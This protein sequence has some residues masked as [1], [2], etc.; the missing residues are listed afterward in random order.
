MALIVDWMLW[1]L[2]LGKERF[3]KRAATDQGIAGQIPE[4][5]YTA[6]LKERVT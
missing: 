1:G 5:R 2:I 3:L 6:D 4:C